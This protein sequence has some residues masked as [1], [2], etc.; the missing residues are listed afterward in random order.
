MKQYFLQF[1]FWN[2]DIN[3]FFFGVIDTDINETP[4]PEVCRQVIRDHYTNINPYDVEIK[5]NAFNN[6]ET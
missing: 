5:I 6:I 4:L 3:K 2:R 1:D